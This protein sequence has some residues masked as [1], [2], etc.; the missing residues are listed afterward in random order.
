M[1]GLRKEKTYVKVTCGYCAKPKT[2][3]S[4]C[5]RSRL[6]R[7]VRLYHPERYLEFFAARHLA[8]ASA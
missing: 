3:W 7:H 5:P 4:P 2:W 1:P 8:E 6:A